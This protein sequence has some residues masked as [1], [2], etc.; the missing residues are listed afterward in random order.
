MLLIVHLY[1]LIS[2]GLEAHNFVKSIELVN[3]M[4]CFIYLFPSWL[5]FTGQLSCLV[6]LPMSR[7]L[8]SCRIY[9]Y[10]YIYTYIHTYIHSTYIVPF[11]DSFHTFCWNWTCGNFIKFVEYFRFSS[12]LIYNKTFLRR[13]LKWLSHIRVACKSSV[14]H[15][16]SH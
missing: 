9:I 11:F 2:P 14:C 15:G 7:S 4:K 3:C 13:T 6:I 12:I 10:I 1:T 5:L 8:S 16:D